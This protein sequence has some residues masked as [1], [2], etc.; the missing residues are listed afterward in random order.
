MSLESPLEWHY[1]LIS[2]SQDPHPLTSFYPTL[3]H[4]RRSSTLETPCGISS[5][6]LIASFS[7][8]NC[9]LH[10]SLSCVPWRE[11]EGTRKME[12]THAEYNLVV[13]WGEKA[14]DSVSVCALVCVWQT[15]RGGVCNIC[16]GACVY[17]HSSR[18]KM[19]ACMCVCITH[20]SIVQS[21]QPTDGKKKNQD[22][23]ARVSSGCLKTWGRLF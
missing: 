14:R 9:C 8:I 12:R 4:W 6:F 1:S 19:N 11:T 5:V 23:S 21:V 18:L 10:Q 20:V 3:L 22:S 15:S 7:D 13:R 17:V 2:S 16:R